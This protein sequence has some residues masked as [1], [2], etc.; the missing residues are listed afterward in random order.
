MEAPSQELIQKLAVALHERVK[1]PTW[2]NF[3]RTGVHTER[4]P[5]QDDW[6]YVRCASVMRKLHKMGPVGVSRLAAEYG[7]KKDRGSAP[8]KA[9]KGSRSIISEVF[10]DLEKAG[11]VAKRAPKGR[12]LSPEGQKMLAKATREVLED[13]ARKDP[14]LKKYL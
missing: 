6:W 11:L 12:M 5:A 14:A 8:Y 9:A 7:G 10:H 4:A 2:A 3:V 1:P 13:L